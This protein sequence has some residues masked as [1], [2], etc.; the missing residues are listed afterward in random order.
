MHIGEEEIS[1]WRWIVGFEV[2]NY[3]LASSFEWYLS[4]TFEGESS[5]QGSSSA[6]WP[7]VSRQ[8]LQTAGSHTH[9]AL[10][11]VS[12]YQMHHSSHHLSEQARCI[13]FL[14]H[15]DSCRWDSCKHLGTWCLQGSS[16]P[17]QQENCNLLDMDSL[18][19]SEKW[20]F[21]RRNNHELL[22]DCS[23]CQSL[24]NLR[25]LNTQSHCNKTLHLERQRQLLEARY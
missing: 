20:M 14:S 8:Q 16:Y 17:R 10:V 6:S 9:F 11:H 2:T 18:V 25:K 5:L 13:A 21:V 1:E 7:F 12:S 3:K 15:R 23:S 4:E 24:Q 22:K 19:V